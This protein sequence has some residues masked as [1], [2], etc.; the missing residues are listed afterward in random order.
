MKL[1]ILFVGTIKHSSVVITLTACGNICKTE[2]FT[3]L[4]YLH[5]L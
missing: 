5:V 3:L 2:T 1:N 4:I